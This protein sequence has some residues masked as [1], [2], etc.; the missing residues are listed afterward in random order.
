MVLVTVEP[1]TRHDRRIVIGVV[2]GK[3]AEPKHGSGCDS[4][5]HA[6]SYHRGEGARG[7]EGKGGGGERIHVS[8]RLGWQPSASEHSSETVANVS[9]CGTTRLHHG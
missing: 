7:R 8:L 4:E 1:H 5:K 2:A 3:C 6:V 9:S